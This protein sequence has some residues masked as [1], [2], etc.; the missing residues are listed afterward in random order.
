MN[1]KYEHLENISCP[2][3]NIS[4]PL[5]LE[6]INPTI[7]QNITKTE[8]NGYIHTN[9]L[10]QYYDNLRDKT[11][12]CLRCQQ[13]TCTRDIKINSQSNINKNNISILTRTILNQLYPDKS[14]TIINLSYKNIKE[15]HPNIFYEYT[16]LTHLYLHNNQI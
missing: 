15:I 9:C 4:C 13:D 7:I 10:Y 5:Y 3:Y 14:I 11:Y 12:K 1:S 2:L 6:Y 8:C 16:N